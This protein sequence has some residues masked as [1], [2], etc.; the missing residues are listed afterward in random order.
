MAV[1]PRHH[2]DG[3]RRRL[4]RRTFLVDL[5]RVSLG[6]VV[7]GPALAGCTADPDEADPDDADPDD[8]AADTGDATPTEADAGGTLA[9]QRAQYE[10]VSA[11]VLVR[12][13]EAVVFDTGPG[14]LVRLTDAMDALGVGFDALGSIILSHRHDDHAGG[15]GDLAEAAPDA[16]L[17][18]VTPDLDL[19]RDRVEVAREV[20]DG[21]TVLGLRIVATPGHTAGHVAAFDEQEGILL[22]GDAIVRDFA[23]GGGTGEGIEVS[24]PSFTADAAQARSSVGVLAD[25]RPSTILFGHGEPVTQDAASMLADV[26]EAL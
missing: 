26:A 4:T 16:V 21:D 15:L 14:G 5:G 2:L 12:G 7:L 6:A 11:Y 18:A 8:D 19:V 9:W 10:I 20:R 1:Q 3:R 24:P 25:L 17:H 23:L 13:G 22:A